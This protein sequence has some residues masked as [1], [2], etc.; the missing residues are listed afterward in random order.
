MP[1]AGE[2]LH[3]L[4]GAWRIV[5]RDAEAWRHFNLSADGL[6]SSFWALALSLPVA[7]FSSSSLWRMARA[8]EPQDEVDFAAFVFVQVGGNV[9]YWAAFLFSMVAVARY[10]ALGQNFAS[11]VI[12]FNWG[13][14][15]TSI[16]FALPLVLYSLGIAG[17]SGAVVL[18]LPAL[19]VLAWYRWQIARTV[20]GASPSIAL[21]I[22]ALDFTLGAIMD[23]GLARL[24]LTTPVSPA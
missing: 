24:V 17:A 19:A 20:L 2:I 14:L 22:L 8:M 6:R 15:L 23:Q 7:F 21:A 18:T 13:T 10:L 3:G 1:S 4:T 12:A 9:L 16:L 5:L 11:Y